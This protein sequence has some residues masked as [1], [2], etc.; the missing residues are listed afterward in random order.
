ME[1]GRKDQDL[2]CRWPLDAYHPPILRTRESRAERLIR[3]ERDPKGRARSPRHAFLRTWINLAVLPVRAAA[4]LFLLSF[5]ARPALAAP[6]DAKTR[7]GLALA[8]RGDCVKAVPLLEDAERARHRPSTAYALA[9]CYAKKGEL[10]RASELFNDVAKDKYAHG[11][12]RDD[13]NAVANAKKKA[14]ELNARIPTLELKPSE[15]YEALEIEIDGEPVTDPSKPRQMMPD[16]QHTIRAR[17][18][19]REPREEKIVLLKSERRVLVL[20][21]EPE[22][23]PPPSEPAAEDPKTSMWLG[24]RLHGVIIPKFAMNIVGE[25]GATFFV[26]GVDATLTTPALTHADLV[27]SL[28]YSSYGMGEVPFK[29]SG[30]PDTEYEILES[31]LHALIATVDLLWSVRLNSTSTLLL[32]FG[33]GVGV[34]VMFA[35]DLYRTQ[36]YSPTGAPGDPYG[37]RKCNGPNDPAGSFR[38]CNQLD[39]D[40]DHY[41]GYAEPSWFKGG[42]RPLLFP[43]VTLPE[44]GLSWRIT[45]RVA[46]DLDLGLTLSGIM[47]ALGARYAL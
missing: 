44:V 42:A 17:A 46:L 12:T 28:G 15:P 27:F 5:S 4:V 22:K 45:P 18:K 37:Y 29:P 38:Y 34:G 23:P 32:R 35:G 9:T 19:G 21:L 24:A 43:W 47:T 2:L 36:A 16:V 6:V 13:V 41:N 31:D 1:I 25:G 10:L 40:D 33:G 11:W 30:R 8:K 26:P 39:K 3:S 20:R 7:Q 14:K